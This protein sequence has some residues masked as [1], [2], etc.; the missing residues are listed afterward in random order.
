LGQFS[1]RYKRLTAELLKCL[2]FYISNEITPIVRTKPI[3]LAEYGV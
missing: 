2:L 1:L 3:P